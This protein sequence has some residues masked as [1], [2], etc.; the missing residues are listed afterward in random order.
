LNLS[1]SVNALPNGPQGMAL[2]GVPDHV[3]AMQAVLARAGLA[4][5]KF[6]GWRC[7]MSYPVPLI[8]MQLA[9]AK[10]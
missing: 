4:E 6:R 3:Q 5:H 10:P 9:L 1:V 7:E 8:E 2:A